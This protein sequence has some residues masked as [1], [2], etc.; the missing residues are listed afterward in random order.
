MACLSFVV[1]CDGCLLFGY[2]DFALIVSFDC[3]LAL[4]SLFVILVD[5]FDWW[6]AALLI[7]LVIL[8][9]LD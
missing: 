9:C 5:Y 1:G 8:D 4:V 7:N 6:V 2:F 3:L